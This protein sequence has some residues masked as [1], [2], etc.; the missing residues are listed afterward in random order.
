[1]INEALKKWHMDTLHSD[2]ARNLYDRLCAACERRPGGM[3]DADQDLIY[4]ACFMEDVKADLRADIQRRGVVA[5]VRNGYQEFKK[6]NKSVTQLRSY[7]DSQRKILAELRITPAKRNAQAVM[8][9]AFD[10]M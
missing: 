8:D 2:C 5:T 6:D 1:M 10:A 3:T 7:M 4:D 9:D